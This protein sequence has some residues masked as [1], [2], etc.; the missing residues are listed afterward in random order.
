MKTPKE[1][2]MNDPSFHHLVNTL[3]Q[4]IHQAEFTPS[5]LREACV[6]ASINYE[7]KHMRDH[8]IDPR[9]NEAFLVLD[10]FV[11]SSQ[12]RKR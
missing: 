11:E 9:L 6:L 7:M 8:H 5:E 3:E 1:K 10:K 12:R 2:Y 4:L